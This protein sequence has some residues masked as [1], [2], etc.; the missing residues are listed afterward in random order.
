MVKYVLAIGIVFFLLVGWLSVQYVYRHFA[1]EHPELG[2][3]R[4]NVAVGCGGC[5]CGGTDSCTSDE[6]C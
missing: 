4:S 1:Q 5:G 6:L 2:P 3:Y